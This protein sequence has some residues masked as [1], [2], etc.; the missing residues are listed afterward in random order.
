[1]IR[2]LRN[3]QLQIQNYQDSL[4][5]MLSMNTATLKLDPIPIDVKVILIGPSELYNLLSMYEENFL[6]TFKGSPNPK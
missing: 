1:M 6:S 5:F 4:G 2:V 3:E